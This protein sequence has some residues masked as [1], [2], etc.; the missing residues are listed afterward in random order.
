MLCIPHEMVL[1]KTKMSKF[2]DIQT[3]DMQNVIFKV[4][5]KYAESFF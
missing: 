4:K 5:T 2:K 3:D 1:E